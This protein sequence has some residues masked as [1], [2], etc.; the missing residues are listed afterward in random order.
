V[1]SFRVR[2]ADWL[3]DQAALRGIR[4]AVFVVEQRVPLE[5]EW[6]AFDEASLHALAEDGEGRP[7][8]TGRLLPD[9]HVGRMAVLPEWRGAGVGTALLLHLIEA[10]RAA[11]L[12]EVVLH[13][14]THAQPFYERHGLAPEGEVFF[15]AGIPHRLM[16]MRLQ[17][18]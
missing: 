11:G 18:A 5:L 1:K 16:R 17:P 14:Q 4:E 7:I 12:R 2:R 10:A 8:G 6:D 15:E 9:G 3:Q 13:A